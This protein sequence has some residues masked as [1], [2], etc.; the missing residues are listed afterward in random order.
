[1]IINAKIIKKPMSEDEINKILKNK[2][3]LK[4]KGKTFLKAQEKYDVNVLY[5][6][7]H[8]LVETG[9]GKSELAKGIKDKDE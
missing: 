7:S 2:G 3:I 9:N 1:M 5:L 4:G 8:A 6:V